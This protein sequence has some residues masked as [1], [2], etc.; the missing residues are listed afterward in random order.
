M[1]HTGMGHMQM[2]DMDMGDMQMGDMQMEV[3]SESDSNRP[4][5]DVDSCHLSRATVDAP[6]FSL[7]GESCTHCLSH[8]QSIPGPTSVTAGDYT[9]RTIEHDPSAINVIN[10]LPPAAPRSLTH[11]DHGP[12]GESSPRHLLN[13]VFRI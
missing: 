10:P 12:P 7:P 9:K 5:P 4:G 1:A 11:L 3:A 2:E 8:S 6:A 13:N